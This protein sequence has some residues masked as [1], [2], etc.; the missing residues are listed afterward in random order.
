MK[1]Y[2]ISGI[3]QMGIGV[4]NV[5]EAWNWYIKQ[6]GMDCRIFEDEAEAKLMLPYTGGEPRSRHAVLALNLQS[7]G[8]FEIWQYKGREPEKIK[9]KIRIG[10]L[11]IIA[12]KM[13]VKNIQDTLSSYQKNR[14]SVPS[15]VSEDPSGKMTFFMND[16]YGN[17]FQLVEATDWLRN[18]KKPT[19]GSYGAI[20]G[21]SDIEK[22]RIVYSDILGYDEV[23]YDKTAIFA[24]LSNLPGGENVCRRVLLR[25]S[26]PFSGPFSKVLGQSVI[27]LIS[28]TG[29]PGKKIYENRFWGDPGFI[30]LC[31][32]MRGMD[33][34]RSFCESKEFPFTVDSKKSHEGNSFDMGEAAGHFSYIEDPDGTLIEFVETHKIPIL[35]K[36]GWYLDLRKRDPNKSLPNWMVNTLKFLRVKN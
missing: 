15:M 34:L 32:D 27:E 26:Q 7:G 3:Q 20:I 22:S 28:T 10:D 19:G 13:K 35:K 30:H 14:I 4:M 29:K 16:P 31:Y 36:F 9:E 8:G 21:V 5:A 23:V 18:E 11:G 12:C 2:I 25:R 17:V 6:F 24:D 33:Q 1:G